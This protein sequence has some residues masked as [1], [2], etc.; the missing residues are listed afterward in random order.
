MLGTLLSPWTRSKKVERNFQTHICDYPKKKAEP[1]V[2]RSVELS[3]FISPALHKFYRVLWFSSLSKINTRRERHEF[4][5]IYLYFDKI[6]A[7]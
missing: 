4:I 3:L 1:S 6:T 5:S 7:I 2:P